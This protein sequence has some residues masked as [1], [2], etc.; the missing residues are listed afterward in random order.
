[1]GSGEEISEVNEFAV[2]LVLNVDDSP[3]VL[4]PTDLLASNNNRLLRA[5]NGE[6]DDILWK[7]SVNI[8]LD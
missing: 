7:V 6:W 5:N 1:M 2:V 4:S 8:K 3:F